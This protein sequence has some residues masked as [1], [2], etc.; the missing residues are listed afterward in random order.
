MS[1]MNDTGLSRRLKNIEAQ[2]I[3][4]TLESTRWNVS[5][6][7]R[8]LGIS[9]QSLYPRLRALGLIRR[10]RAAVDGG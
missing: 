5:E 8:I 1:A 6:T 3:R 2:I 4:E 10:P 7:A 9:R